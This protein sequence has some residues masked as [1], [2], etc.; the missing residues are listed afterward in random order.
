MGF[1]RLNPSYL[2]AFRPSTSS[3]SSTASTPTTTAPRRWQVR[4]ML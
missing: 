1:A 4:A 3:G 2:L